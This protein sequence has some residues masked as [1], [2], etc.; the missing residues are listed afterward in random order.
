MLLY[1]YEESLGYEF[2]KIFEDINISKELEN[3]IYSHTFFM[4]LF[5]FTDILSKKGCYRS[6][7]EYFFSLI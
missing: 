6:A 7:L 4:T 2:G 1:I 5:K 3:N